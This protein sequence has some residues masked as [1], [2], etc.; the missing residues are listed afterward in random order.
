MNSQST[1]PKNVEFTRQVFAIWLYNMQFIESYTRYLMQPLL[2][3]P[4]HVERAR[5]RTKQRTML[6]ERCN[7]LLKVATQSS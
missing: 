7:S 6:N 5:A 2:P 1:N 4:L 3:N